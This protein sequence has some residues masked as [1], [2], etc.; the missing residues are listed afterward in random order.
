[1][2]SR[3]AGEE[4]KKR[5]NDERKKVA[6]VKGRFLRKNTLASIFKV[7]QQAVQNQVQSAVRNYFLIALPRRGTQLRD[8]THHSPHPHDRLT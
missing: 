5:L 6:I 8:T 7:E 3:R 1:M 4:Q 2:S